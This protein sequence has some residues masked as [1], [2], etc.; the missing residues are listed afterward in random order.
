MASRRFKEGLA[1]GI[2]LISIQPTCHAID[3]VS[4]EFATGNKTEITRIGAQWDWQR[5]WR[6]VDGTHIGGNWDLTL[7]QWRQQRYLDTPDNTRKLVAIGIT[8]VFRWQRNDQNGLYAEAG[9]G[10]HYLSVR[11]NNNARRL[12]TNFQFASHIGVGYVFDSQLDI[13]MKI[14][15]ISNGGIEKPNGGVNFA[16]VRVTYRF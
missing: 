12:S 4:F 14:Q 3:S 16:V 8:P 10:A 15:H 1:A 6:Q 11:Y 9:A 13:C 7:A 5:R 2:V